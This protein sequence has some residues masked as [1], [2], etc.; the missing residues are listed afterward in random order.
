MSSPGIN[1]DNR[2][3]WLRAETKA[4][5]QRTLL[6]PD[7]A[8]RLIDAGYDVVVERC[9]Q[10]TFDGSEYGA[11]GCRLVAA[12][13]W[14]DAPEH[15]IVMGLKE[16]EVSDGPFSRRH[17]HFAHVYKDQ[18]G[19]QNLLQQF[20][21]DGGSLY[22]LEYLTDDAGR[23]IAAFGYWA[24]FVGA[25]VSL[26]AFC[27]KHNAE[28]LGGLNAWPDK[29]ALVSE[30]KGKLAKLPVQPTALVMGALGRCGSGAVELFDSCGIR[31]TQW[32]Q[33][34]T[35]AGGPFD[36]I[37]EHDVLVNCVFVNAPL[38]AFTSL[39]HL[40]QPH[41]QLQV[42]SDVSCDPFGQYN[43]LPIY[44]RC[45]TM[46]Q[47]VDVVAFDD[48]ASDAKETSLHLVTI[49]HLPSLLPRESSEDFAARLLPVLMDIDKLDQDAWARAH[50][51][52]LHHVQ[53][54]GEEQ[55][56]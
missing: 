29:S 4:F 25:A 6:T 34:E 31:C 28:V 55:T 32:D 46:A 40:S 7:V 48:A 44:D 22:D 54:L 18:S 20:K 49:D 5:E 56:S 51:I 42:I 2:L 39:E 17:V 36:A 13:S 14:H 19:W 21:N 26:L 38:P 30:L 9:T 43:P 35:A 11:S 24:G 12:H 16:L 15:A 27:A 47:P 10:R 37:R 3:L 41:R 53:R 33:K 1:S 8:S 52:F 50:D 23:R 45:T